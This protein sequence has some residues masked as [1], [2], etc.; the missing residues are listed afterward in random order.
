MKVYRIACPSDN[1]FAQGP[2]RIAA[3]R[4]RAQRTLAR[5]I[6]SEHTLAQPETH[7]TPREDG[8]DWRAKH[9][10]YEYFFGFATERQL[11]EWFGGWLGL[12]HAAGYKIYVYD[13]DTEHI[14]LSDSRRQL[15]F[16]IRKARLIKTKYIK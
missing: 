10:I 12:L 9:P 7:P 14:A 1:G 6:N 15:A 16:L 4:T 13:V 5:R 11:R 8:I 3:C 2:Y